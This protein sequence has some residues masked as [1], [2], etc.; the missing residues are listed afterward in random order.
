MRIFLEINALTGHV[1]WGPLRLFDPTRFLGPTVL[2][3]EPLAPAAQRWIDPKSARRCGAHVLGK[4]I[5]SPANKRNEL[6]KGGHPKIISSKKDGFLGSMLLFP[7]QNPEK[8][9]ILPG[10]S[11]ILIVATGVIRTGCTNKGKLSP[12][13]R[14]SN[15]MGG[16]Q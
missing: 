5:Q 3:F 14:P 7:N 9:P 6:S 1:A 11:H 2:P 15:T 10:E 13:G 4:K 8:N 16:P 12:S